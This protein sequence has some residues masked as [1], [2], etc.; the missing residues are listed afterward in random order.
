M[1]SAKKYNDSSGINVQTA[2]YFAPTVNLYLLH[3]VVGITY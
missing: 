3:K 2:V 1:A